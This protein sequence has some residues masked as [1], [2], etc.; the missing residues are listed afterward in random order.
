VA[1]VQ[2]MRIEEAKQHLERTAMATDEI[3]AT[4][5][6]EDPAFFRRLFRRHTGITPARYRQRCQTLLDAGAR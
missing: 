4:V 3:A 2:T 5:G 6:Y 1:Y